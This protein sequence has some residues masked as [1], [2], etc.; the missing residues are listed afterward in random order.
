M[1]AAGQARSKYS[2]SDLALRSV[3]ELERM[4]AG[5]D[6]NAQVFG[7]LS[8]ALMQT[9]EPAAG[10]VQFR[11][12]EPGY[13][14]P[15]ERLYRSVSSAPRADLEQIQNY[16][17]TV[18]SHLEALSKGQ[19]EAAP[20]MLPVCVALHQEL[21]QELSAEDV[22]AIHE[23]PLFSEDTSSGLSSA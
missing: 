18:S 4:G 3:V 10:A 7:E 16:M 19:N 8:T 14:D 23:W 21:V 6:Y 17:K 5:M 13:Y 11:F 15:F 2:L 9:S 22:F 12:V 1:H 20:T